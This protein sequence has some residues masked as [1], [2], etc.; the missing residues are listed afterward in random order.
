LRPVYEE[1]PGF[2]QDLSKL[3][4][5]RDMPAEAKEYI[6]MIEHYTGLKV[7]Y[8]SVGPGKDDVIKR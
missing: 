8:V 6:N 4:D 2:D 3:R 7:T 1:M 5:Y